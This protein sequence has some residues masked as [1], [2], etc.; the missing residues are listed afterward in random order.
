VITPRFRERLS[1]RVA[2]GDV[3]CEVARL[4]VMRVEVHVPE[5]DMDLPAVGQ[6][7][8]ARF[9]SIP[10]RTFQ[11]KVVEIGQ[12]VESETVGTVTT[13]FVRVMSEVR[14]PDGAL[15]A[16]LSGYAVVQGGR[17]TLLGLAFR[18]VRRWVQLNVLS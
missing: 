8:T 9:A 4:D 11:G 7:L 13:H 14:N 1:E 15:R 18:K 6:Q 10:E 12:A 5:A 16:G 2:A 17:T 3:I